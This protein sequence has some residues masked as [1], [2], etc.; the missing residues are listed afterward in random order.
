MKNDTKLFIALIILSILILV[1]SFFHFRETI[2]GPFRLPKPKITQLTNEELHQIL[3]KKDTDNDGLSDED[4]VFKYHTSIYLEDSD[5]DGYNDKEEVE[6]GSDPTNPESTPLKKIAE[7]TK[8]EEKKELTVEEIRDIL[9]KA[10]FPKEILEKVDDET[11]KKLYNETI[12]ETGINPE[13]LKQQTGG[14]GFLDFSRIF[15]KLMTNQPEEVTNS[16]NFEN[17]DPA[18]IRQLMLTAGADPN[19]LNQIDDQTLKTL[20]LQALKEAQK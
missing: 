15:Q 3:A 19:L 7:T 9:I 4:E 16:V 5:S 14:L 13:A 6:A 20:F 10:G 12:K 11:L 18:T 2:Q 17:L 8:I 1:F